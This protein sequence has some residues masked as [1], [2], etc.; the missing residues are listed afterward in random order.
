M[1]E[2][3]TT[4]AAKNTEPSANDD[5]KTT[6]PSQSGSADDKPKS[7]TQDDLDRLLAKTRREEKAKYEKELE[8][9]NKSEVERLKADLAERD[10]KLA[11]RETKDAV[12]S[13]LQKSGY[14]RP[15]AASLLLKSSV[16]R[17][18]DEGSQKIQRPDFR[19]C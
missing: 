12:T 11:E 8:N 2:D 9:V 4:D 14:K 1:A 19:A 18:K 3:N 17:D 5:P 6:T 13:C 15:E 10:A 7:F 16:S